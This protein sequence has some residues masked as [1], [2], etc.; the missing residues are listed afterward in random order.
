MLVWLLSLIVIGLSMTALAI[1]VLAG[2]TPLR[3]TCCG[4]S[5]AKANGCCGCSADQ[6]QTGAR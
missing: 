5:C 3:E 6:Q 2:R 1:G 4:S